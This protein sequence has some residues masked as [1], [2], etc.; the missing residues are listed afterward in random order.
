MH[1]LLETVEGSLIP[2]WIDEGF[3][4]TSPLVGEYMVAYE[5]GEGYNFSLW[6]EIS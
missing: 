4:R 5:L 3:M 1:K 6:P 2:E